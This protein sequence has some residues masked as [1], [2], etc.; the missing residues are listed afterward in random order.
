MKRSGLLITLIFLFFSELFAQVPQAI[1]Y[2]LIVRDNTGNVLINQ[3]LNLRISIIYGSSNGAAV[4]IEEQNASTNQFGLV[5]LKVGLGEVILG[6]FSA[7]N[8]STGNYFIKVEIGLTT[9]GYQ[10]LGTTSLLA[11]PYALYAYKSDS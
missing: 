10:T 9:G 5:N 7:I 3:P 2:Q 11:V 4:Y 1:S 8:W 6:N